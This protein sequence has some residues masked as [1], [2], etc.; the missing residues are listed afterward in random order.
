MIKKR[1]KKGFDTAGFDRAKLDFAVKPGSVKPENLIKVSFIPD[2]NYHFAKMIV[3][4]R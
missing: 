1:N 2:H 4:E 3:N